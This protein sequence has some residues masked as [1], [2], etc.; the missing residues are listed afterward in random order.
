MLT[1]Q[2]IARAIKLGD[3][4]VFFAVARKIFININFFTTIQIK[5]YIVVKKLNGSN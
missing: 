2:I 5:L 3:T 1:K 4:G